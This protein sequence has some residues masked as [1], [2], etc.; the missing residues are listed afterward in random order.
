LR[1]GLQS[2]D[3]FLFETMATTIQALAYHITWT[4]YGTSLPGDKRGWVKG[5]HAGIEDPNWRLEDKARDRMAEAAVLLNFAQRRIVEETITDHCEIRGWKLH[6]VNARTNHVHV[7][8]AA[9]REPNDVMNQLKAWCSQKL[10]DAAGLTEKVALK[11]GRR[12][13]FTEGGDKELVH[14]AMHLQNAI[15]Y[16]L[17]GQ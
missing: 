13:W 2:N 15:R 12:R 4:T 10:S 6:A 8:V 16:V 7:L 17:E 1:F 3:L 5:G 14:D 9:Q 11:A